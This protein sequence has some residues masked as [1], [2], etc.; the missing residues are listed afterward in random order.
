MEMLLAP[1]EYAR[2]QIKSQSLCS[3]HVQCIIAPFEPVKAAKAVNFDLSFKVVDLSE[4]TGK[5][6]AAN[7][8]FAITVIIYP[9]QP[10][11]IL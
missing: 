3:H 7:S 4:K 5:L 9:W 8:V 10:T 11:D 2:R 1:D 6:A